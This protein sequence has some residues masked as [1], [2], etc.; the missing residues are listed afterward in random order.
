LLQLGGKTEEADFW[1][2][3]RCPKALFLGNSL[4]SKRHYQIDQVG[5]HLLEMSMAKFDL[6]ARGYTRILKVAH[7]IANLEGREAIAPHHLS[8]AIQYRVLDRGIL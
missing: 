8:E 1:W 2:L 3:Y 6:S 5:N 4:S 7:T